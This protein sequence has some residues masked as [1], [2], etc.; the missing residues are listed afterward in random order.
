MEPN[1]RIE[2]SASSLR[3]RIAA[4]G[5]SASW[6]PLATMP[7]LVSTTRTMGRRGMVAEVGIEPF[8]TITD[9]M[10]VVSLPRL[11]VSATDM[12]WSAFR[13]SNPVL[14][15]LQLRAFPSSSR[16]MVVLAGIEPTSA[17]LQH[18]ANPSQLQNHEL[19]SSGFEPEPPSM[20]QRYASLNT[21]T[22]IVLARGVEPLA[23]SVSR[24]RSTAELS[25]H[26]W[27]RVEDCCP[28]W[29]CSRNTYPTWLPHPELNRDHGSP[30]SVATTASYLLTRAS[31]HHEENGPVSCWSASLCRPELRTVGAAYE[32]RTRAFTM[33]R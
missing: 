29:R 28:H 3:R 26:R 2:L 19:R 27:S 31:L 15:R 22:A 30:L 8:A 21:L 12:R 10:R 18:A 17:W 32:N 16:R 25:E 24:K 20:S 13:E 4:Q 6:S 33:A 14:R 9:L 5:H 11:Y 7:S 1:E 23:S